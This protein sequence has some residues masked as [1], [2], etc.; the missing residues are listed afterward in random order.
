LVVEVA[1]LLCAALLV[2]VIAA[3]F[4]KSISITII[5]LFYA[6]IVLGLIFTI[7]Q[8]V[9]IGL[10]H[11]TTFAGAMSVMLMTVVLMTGEE[12]LDIGNKNLAAILAAVTILVVAASSYSLFSNTPPSPQTNL[13]STMEILSF[14]WTFRP[15]DLLILVIVFAAAMIGVVNLL[16]SK[17]EASA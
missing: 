7:Y 4:S 1:I 3:I 15:W 16:S 6:S 14:I 11:I 13:P 8:G 9:V 17:E 5:M 12:K 2:T 10:L